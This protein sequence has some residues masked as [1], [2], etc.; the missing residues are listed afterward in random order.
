M[1]Q[2][3]T[4]DLPGIGGVIKQDPTDFYV[5]EMPLYAP[6]G[7]GAHTF[8]EIEKTGLSTFE[9]VR[10]IARALNVSQAHIGYAGLKDAQAVTRQVLSV[11]RV[12]PEAVSDLQLPGIR[13]RWAKRHRNKLK[14]GHLRGNRFTIRV[15]DVSE[16]AEPA[17]QAILDVLIRRGVPNRYGPQR[18]G[19]RGDS[20]R[21]GRSVVMGDAR[22]FVQ[23]FLGR[24]HPN[25]SE[26]VQAARGRFEAGDWEA[27]LALLPGSMADERHALMA[28]L[29]SHGDYWRA[30]G[31]VPK[32]LKT[33]L[34]SAYQSVLFNRVLD[35]RL[36]SLD[37]VYAGDL[38]VKHPGH[39]IFRVLDETVEQPRARA[40]E[41]SPTGPIF[42]F[43]MMQPTGTQGDAEAE[44]LASEGLSLDSF[45]GA[46]GIRAEGARRAL[47]FEINEPAISYDEGIVLQFWLQPGCY[48]TAV[49][50]ELMKVPTEPNSQSDVMELTEL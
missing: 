33:F 3:L 25:E 38:A 30:Y 48:A 40:F 20:G 44:I 9:A 21:L 46:A 41:I 43:K 45:R 49:L 15:R 24:P 11:E 29:Q 4:Y 37:R 13:V 2:Y 16:Q 36:Q 47:R 34:L 39:S 7:D 5:E 50:A 10:A 26:A 18:F 22:G 17:C 6:I 42:G 8:F 1:D 23:A 28:L 32:R 31:A 12:P 14:I 19:M 27:A 35:A